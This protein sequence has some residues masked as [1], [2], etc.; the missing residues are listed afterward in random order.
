MS[1][2]FN[3]LRSLGVHRPTQL[4]HRLRRAKGSWNSSQSWETPWKHQVPPNADTGLSMTSVDNLLI[5]HM[6]PKICSYESLYLSIMISRKNSPV[7][8]TSAGHFN[9]TDHRGT[10]PPWAKSSRLPCKLDK[11]KKYC[12][13]ALR[14]DTVVV[15]SLPHKQLGDYKLGYDTSTFRFTHD[16]QTLPCAPTVNW[17][18][19]D[20]TLKEKQRYR[21]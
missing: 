6:I 20:R 2:V 8:H 10:F 14:K 16:R 21:L 15:L 12:E 4:H 5:S 7:E 13:L 11:K 9:S 17:A 1:L 3:C 18:I 19:G